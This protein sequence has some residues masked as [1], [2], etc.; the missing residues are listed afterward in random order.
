M[1]RRRD[2]TGFLIWGRRNPASL[3]L[4]QQTD[5][6]KLKPSKDAPLKRPID[7][8]PISISAANHQEKKSPT[9]GLSQLSGESQTASFLSV[10]QQPVTIPPLSTS[11]TSMSN[12]TPVQTPP[13]LHPSTDTYITTGKYRCTHS[14]ISTIIVIL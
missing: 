10:S 1:S 8:D 13:S 7:E 2:K 11:T 3:P 9:N 4:P 12:T 5:Y 14:S 6:L